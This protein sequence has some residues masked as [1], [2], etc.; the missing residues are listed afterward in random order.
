MDN[1]DI[2]QEIEKGIPLSDV[3]DKVEYDN[4]KCKYNKDWENE[5]K[6]DPDM[7]EEGKENI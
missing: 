6:F 5:F 1:L 7:T 2:D 4:N 3:V